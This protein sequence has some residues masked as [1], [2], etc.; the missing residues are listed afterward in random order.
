MHELLTERYGD[1]FQ[2]LPISKRGPGSRFM[3]DFEAAKKDFGSAGPRTTSL[4]L[5]MKDIKA[6]DWN[7]VQY[8][9]EDGEVEFT[10]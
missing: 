5:I 1:A 8:D 7:C 6:G 10:Q 4:R 9:P 3:S 2:S